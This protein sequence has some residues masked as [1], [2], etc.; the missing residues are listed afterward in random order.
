MA[1][2]PTLSE[3]NLRRSV[4]KFFLDG[5]PGKHVIFDRSFSPPE[6]QNILEWVHIRT[7]NML[8]RI[9]SEAVVT[10]YMFTRQDLE[11][12]RL[13]ELRD[14]VMELIYPCHLTLYDESWNNVGGIIFEVDNASD[15]KYTEN[16]EKVEFITLILQWGGKWSI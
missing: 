6:D 4:K 12:D 5:L 8:P 16:S 3:A 9:V 15:H 1:L 11:G 10:I 7:G 14:E 13:A 2:H